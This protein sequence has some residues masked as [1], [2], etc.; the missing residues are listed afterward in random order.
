MTTPAFLDDVNLSVHPAA[1]RWLTL[2]D[3]RQVLGW[4]LNG[5]PAFRFRW[6]PSGLVTRRQLRD[7]RMC[8]G[9]HEPYGLLV[10]RHGWRWSWLYRLDLAKASHAASPAQLDALDKAM[11]ARRRCRLC[12]R[13]A[14]YC[15]PTSDGRCND[16][17]EG[18]IDGDGGV[19]SR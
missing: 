18:Q 19:W 8:P 4:L 6:A 17:I 9:G 10:W 12:G 1:A 7:L 11:A 5:V 2:W 13:D 16:C 15:V 3:G 14:G